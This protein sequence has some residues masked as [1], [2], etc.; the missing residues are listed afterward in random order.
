MPK[1]DSLKKIVLIALATTFLVSCGPRRMRCGPYR[2]MVTSETP[3]K[4]T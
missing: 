1:K 2:C 3:I 4:N